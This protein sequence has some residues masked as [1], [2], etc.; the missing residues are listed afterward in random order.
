MLLNAKPSA[1][2]CAVAQRRGASSPHPCLPRPR[3]VKASVATPT[4]ATSPPSSITASSEL[5]GLGRLS[6]IV[7]D[8]LALEALTPGAK[9]AAGSVSLTTLRSILL[10]G[11]STGLKPY[12]N[13]INAALTAGAASSS[14]PLAAASPLDRA[15]VNVGAMMVDAVWGRVETQVDP[16]LAED[17]AAS[18][19]LRQQSL[20]GGEQLYMVFSTVQGVAAMQAGVSVLR[21]NVGRIREWH[22]KNPGVMMNQ[23]GPREAELAR[24]DPGLALVQ[25]LYCYGRRFHPKSAIMAMG[26]RTRQGTLTDARS[27]PQ[28]VTLHTNALFDGEAERDDS[29]YT[30]GGMRTV[31]SL[32]TAAPALNS[33]E[34]TMRMPSC[35][36]GLPSR[37]DSS[38]QP[39][40]RRELVYSVMG[41]DMEPVTEEAWR[42]GLGPLA[43]DLLAA[44]LKLR[45]SDV[46]ELQRLLSARATST[47]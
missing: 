16:N 45:T 9:L 12:E 20:L 39:S 10:S 34:L 29:P 25:Q 3:S 46:A 15:L 44:M 38:A 26:L 27:S 28:P 47:D 18:E 35:R 8:T 17:Q 22:D 40:S 42:E 23:F 32:V 19:R 1:A 21:I 11:S 37:S 5:Q 31:D 6:T 36:Y 30:Q 4:V 33:S 14:S 7:P 13:A 41:W 2:H 24:V 43:S